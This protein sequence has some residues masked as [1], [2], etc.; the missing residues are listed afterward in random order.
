MTI[1]RPEQFKGKADGLWKLGLKSGDKTG[2]PEVDQFY[3]VAPGMLTIITG[4][5]GSGKS[6]W[7]DALALNLAAQGWIFAV[8]SPENLP[9]ELH[10]S[11]WLEK[12]LNKPFAEGKSR[13]MTLDEVS[14]GI[15]ELTKSFAFIV[16]KGEDA[17][18]ITQLIDEASAWFE[19]M[20]ILVDDHKRALIIDPWNE[21]DQQRP[22]GISETEWISQILGYIRRWARQWK[23][24]VFLVAHPQK[25]P[26]EN[27][28]LPI[29]RPDMISGS[30]HWWN[31]A[32]CCIT[33]HREIADSYKPDVDVFIQK[34]KFKHIG[35]VGRATLRYIL[36]TGRYESTSKPHDPP[37]HWSDGE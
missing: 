33:I 11:K 30:Q 21:I 35:R 31:K 9:H 20:A 26:R 13:R 18:T 23:V 5:P 16:P 34:V 28:K 32:D 12:F 25:Q 10:L 22:A 37:P 2:W 36:L 6:E 1:I 7:L 4:W 29:P 15:A 8:Y 14:E 24:H 3:T 19:D 17:A 27:G